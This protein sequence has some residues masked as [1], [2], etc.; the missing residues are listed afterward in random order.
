MSVL[1]TTPSHTV[2]RLL[3]AGLLAVIA[4]LA[5][6]VGVLA[7]GSGSAAAPATTPSVHS[8]PSAPQPNPCLLPRLGRQG[9]C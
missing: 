1:S 9:S 5:V 4:A 8:L 3:I 7:A 6:V 2:G